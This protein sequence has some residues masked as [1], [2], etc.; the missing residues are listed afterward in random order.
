[1]RQPVFHRIFRYNT[2]LLPNKYLA[3]IEDGICTID[4]ARLLT[5][6]TIGYPGWGI[7]YYML[8][9]HLNRQ[10][11]EIILETGTNWG[12]TTIILAQ[13][14]IDSGCAGRVITFEFD[15]DNVEKALKNFDAASV[16]DRVEVH[17]GNSLHL[18]PKVLERE[19][20][21]RFALLDASHMYDD[22]MKEF[23]IVLPRLANDA[24]VVFDNTYRIAEEHED[25]R[26]NGAL[27][28]IQKRHG[29][30]LINFEFVSWYTPGLAIWQR[31]PML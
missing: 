19:S 29:G 27:K 23:E 21:I 6:A 20:G 4:E 16:S 11:Y 30:N 22:V 1:M 12:C 13:A 8:L 31:Q 24:L 25:Q 10:Q 7:I 5:G 28:T 26:V 14:L 3:T 15:T 17:A 18:M 9:S 2:A